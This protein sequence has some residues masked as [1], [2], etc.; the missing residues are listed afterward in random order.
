MRKVARYRSALL[1]VTIAGRLTLHN[2][3][4]RAAYS[5]VLHG[6]GQQL[7]AAVEELLRN[8]VSSLV[9]E[10]SAAAATSHCGGP[11]RTLHA[12]CRS[13]TVYTRGVAMVNDV[14]MYMVRRSCR[15]NELHLRDR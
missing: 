7:Y 4:F 10:G 3:V 8:H 9:S 13:W 6:R 1:A 15:T 2:V 12:L 5:L 14:V 11:L